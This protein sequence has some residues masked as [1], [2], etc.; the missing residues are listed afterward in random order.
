MSLF[1]IREERAN[2]KRYYSEARKDLLRDFANDE[3]Q[4][5][6][7]SLTSGRQVRRDGSLGRK[8]SR[9]EQGHCA[10]FIKGWKAY[11]RKLQ[12]QNRGR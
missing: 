3:Y 10:G 5:C 7:T 9:E 11:R 4:R 8:L 6:V 2:S 12:N 1:G